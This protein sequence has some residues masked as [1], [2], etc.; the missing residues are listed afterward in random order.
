MAANVSARLVSLN[1][2]RPKK[3][4][5]PA[6]RSREYRERKRQNIVSADAPPR[7]ADA[8]VTLRSITP[9]VTSRPVTPSCVTSITPPV[10][11]S[12]RHGRLPEPPAFAELE[13]TTAELVTACQRGIEAA[14]LMVGRGV[15]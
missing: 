11:P 12:R 3:A 10:T 15:A 5:T 9:A 2:P 4:K 13:K 1:Q 6:E 8:S 7:A 14:R